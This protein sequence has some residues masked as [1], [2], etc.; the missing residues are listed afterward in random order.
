M[1][2]RVWVLKVVDDD[3]T[4]AAA[5]AADCVGVGVAD[6]VLVVYNDQQRVIAAALA[7]AARQ[8][9]GTVRL[10][11]FAPLSRHGEEPPVEVAEALAWADVV[12]AP[13]SFSLTQTQAR[14]RATSSGTRFAS[15]PTITEQIF[16]RTICVDYADLQRR[17][18]DLASRLTA[19]STATITSE[20]GARLVLSL[21]GRMGRNDAGR[22]RERGAVGNLPAGEAYIAPVETV[23]DGVVVLD[24]SVAGYGVLSSPLRLTLEA[25]RVVDADGEAAEW[26]L[27]MLDA[28]GEHGRSLAELGIGTNPAAVLSG[29]VLEDEKAIGTAHVAFGASAGIGGANLAGVHIDGVMTRPTVALDDERVLEDGQLLIPASR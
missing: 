20:P 15:L 7:A 4:V 9:A 29:N 1:V 17:G 5:A 23:G 3:L 6:A 14:M 8:R 27:D 25:G 12:F 19:A 21:S 26:L 24:G 11:C 22:L 10:I 18:D 28:G 13:T 16:C 2:L